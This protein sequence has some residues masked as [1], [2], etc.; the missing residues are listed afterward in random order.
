MGVVGGVSAIIWGTLAFTLGGYE[1]FKFENSLI[2]AIYPTSRQ[3][4]DPDGGDDDSPPTEQ[5][6]KHAM[7]R[8]VA[9]RGRYWYT[10]SE[11]L[12]IW[13]LNSF[14]CCFCRWS[15]C[16]QRRIKRLE[17]HEAASEKLANEIDIV[18]FL[19]AQRIGQFIA[20]LN[21]KKHQRAL[22]T[23]FKKY[24]IDNLGQSSAANASAE[25]DETSFGL[26]QTTV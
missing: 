21:L 23:S 22:V 5:K 3:D 26:I 9:E 17:R 8:T 12:L 7:M 4:Y 16:F 2:S 25:D 1:S 20:K 24:Q 11:Y 19:H 18:N 15:S 10:Y 13:F 6:A 14:C